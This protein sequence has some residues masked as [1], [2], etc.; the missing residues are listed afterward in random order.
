MAMSSLLTIL[1]VI[2]GLA[3]ST[4]APQLLMQALIRYQITPT[5]LEIT[6]FGVVPIWRCRVGVME[7]EMTTLIRQLANPDGYWK[8]LGMVNKLSWHYVLIHRP[9]GFFRHVVISLRKPD[10]FI[11]LLLAN[12][13]VMRHKIDE[14]DRA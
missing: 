5:Y 9:S 8:Y 13:A 7:V 1:W 11:K 2:A 14:G 4:V 12:G 10:D 6:L 3:V